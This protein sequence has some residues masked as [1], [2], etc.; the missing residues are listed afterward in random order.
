V[1]GGRG[2]WWLR[3]VGDVRLGLSDVEGDDERAALG[4]GELVADLHVG[5]GR[6][7]D[8]VDRHRDG[9]L[10]GLQPL[11]DT[12]RADVLADEHLARG[13]G[14][15][16]GRRAGG[17]GGQ[18]GQQQNEAFHGHSASQLDNQPVTAD[19]VRASRP[20]STTRLSPHNTVTT[21]AAVPTYM[22][23]HHG[24]VMK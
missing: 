18:N 11:V 24:H 10:P 8:G 13:L 17:A 15:V 16:A 6:V 14:V 12:G 23:T 9:V 2:G 4:V 3:T 21:A 22:E 1:G 7:G 5:A 19:A 20:I